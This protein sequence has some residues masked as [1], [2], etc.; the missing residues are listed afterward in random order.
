MIRVKGRYRDQILELE[1]PL[2]LAEGTEVEIDIHLAEEVQG[3]EQQGW[4][5]LGMRR[6]EQEWD[7]PEDAVYDDWKKLYGV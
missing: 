7:N 3:S 2:A 4:A 5:E 1:Q 6:L